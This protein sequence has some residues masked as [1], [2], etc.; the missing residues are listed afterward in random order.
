MPSSRRSLS[1]SSSSVSSRGACRAPSRSRA[2]SNGDAGI[3]LLPPTR[4]IGT[5]S[6]CAL[7]RSQR[8]G[9]PVISS[10]LRGPIVIG[11]TAVFESAASLGPACLGREGSLCD[12]RS[13]DTTGRCSAGAGISRSARRWPHAPNAHLSHRALRV[14]VACLIRRS[15]FAPRGSAPPSA[16]CRPSRTRPGSVLACCRA[17]RMQCGP[18]T[19][20]LPS[21]S[22]ALSRSPPCPRAGKI[23]DRLV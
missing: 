16:S 4:Q 1:R 2:L 23:A 17:V 9:T 19:V 6:R 20:P 13:C 11:V 14:R 7:S 10:A 8:Q 5:P 21:H 18:L 12:G 22:I 3:T 15:G